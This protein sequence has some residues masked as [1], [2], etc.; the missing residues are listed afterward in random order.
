[1][2]DNRGDQLYYVVNHVFLP[3]KLP[4]EDDLDAT[5]EHALCLLVYDAAKL[6]VDFLP[7]YQHEKWHAI[8]DM[9]KNI[10]LS[11]ETEELSKGQIN[12]SMATMQPKG[13]RD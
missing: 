6:Y 8:V 2:E 12:R 10:H 13:G 7:P 11:H 5:M 4:Q 3:P 9:L 1:M